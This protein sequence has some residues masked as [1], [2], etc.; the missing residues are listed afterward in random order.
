MKEADLHD[1]LDSTLT[2]VH[3]ELKNRVEIRRDYG[4]IPPVLCYPSRLNQVFLNLLVN[5]SHAI[6][7]EGR[8]TIRTLHTN[9]TVVVEIQDS[10]RG[11]PEDILPHI[12]ESGFTTKAEGEGTG[13]G[14]AISRQIVDDHG[15]QIEVAS[16]QGE[17]T[18]FRVI[19]PVG[20]STDK[21]K[22]Q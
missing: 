18:T 12:F 14:L 16:L 6:D 8:I 13:L 5:A 19:L 2:L 9:N 17:G 7:G 10:G 1:G 4:D 15:G 11:M 22:V 21:A 20:V 3:H